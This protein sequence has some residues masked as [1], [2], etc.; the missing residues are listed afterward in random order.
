[1]QRVFIVT[2]S[3][4]LYGAYRNIEDAEMCRDRSAEEDFEEYITRNGIEVERLTEDEIADLRLACGEENGYFN[5]TDVTMEDCDDI[6]E[7]DNLTVVDSEGHMYTY[8]E[9]EGRIDL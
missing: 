6:D 8:N 3:G 9:I 1:M 2:Q 7:K 5:I 4:E